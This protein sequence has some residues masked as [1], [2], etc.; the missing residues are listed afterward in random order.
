M[1]HEGAVRAW[2]SRSAVP[3]AEIDDLIQ[4]AYCRL[5]ELASFDHVSNPRNYF[6]MV[7]RNLLNDRAV[8]KDR[9]RHSLRKAHGLHFISA[10][11]AM[12]GYGAF[13]GR[14]PHDACVRALIARPHVP[15]VSGFRREYRRCSSMACLVKCGHACSSREHE[16][17]G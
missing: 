16:R 1:P 3:Q 2:L 5:A 17:G 4:E 6:F 15:H 12:D 7:A 10:A 13:E 14:W 11:N 8:P 9:G